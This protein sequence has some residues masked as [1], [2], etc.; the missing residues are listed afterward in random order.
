MGRVYREKT[1]PIPENTFIDQNKVMLTL[2]EAEDGKKNPKRMLIGYVVENDDM[3]A[4]TLMHPNSNYQYFLPDLWKKYCND[5]SIV[6][7]SLSVG[8]FALI[9]LVIHMNGLYPLL[10]NIFG[11]SCANSIIDLAMYS[12]TFRD[13]SF[14]LVSERLKEFL[15]FSHNELEDSYISNLLNNLLDKNKIE[16]FKHEWLSSYFKNKK[17]KI[18]IGGDGSNNDNKSESSLAEKGHAKSGKNEDIIGFMLIV[19]AETNDPISYDLVPG[20]VPDCKSFRKIIYDL[21]AYNVTIEAVVLDRNFCNMNVINILDEL[22]LPYI[23]MSPSDNYGFN[24]LIDKYA[25]D[26][27]QDPDY[28]FENKP[29][30]GVTEYCQIFKS[31]EYCAY[32]NLIYEDVNGASRR[33]TFKRKILEEI[34]RLKELK[35]NSKDM[36][37]KSEF[38]KFIQIT[39]SRDIVFNKEN[40]LHEL[41]K[42]GSYGIIS[43]ENYGPEVTNEKYSLRNSSCEGQFNV[44]KTQ[45]GYDTFRSHSTEGI[46]SRMFIAFITIIIRNVI[47]KLSKNCMDVNKLVVKLSRISMRLIPGKKYVFIDDMSNTIKEFLQKVDYLVIIFIIYKI[48]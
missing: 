16:Q 11:V 15:T 47:F 43:K 13:N 28:L 10:T 42:K 30:S 21:T 23:I 40:Y 35:K 4:T 46:N 45:L 38:S 5:N 36:K 18:L 48:L 33:D 8:L 6:R 25:L 41:N 12:I 32:M 27:Q 44:I 2:G 14:H 9:N 22:H 39:D 17:V 37:V 19:D 7:Y 31:E 34:G 20:S 29:L 1:V 26:L 24:L 3:S